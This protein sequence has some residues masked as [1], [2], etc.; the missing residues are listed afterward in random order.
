MVPNH[1]RPWHP[2]ISL[3][4]FPRLLC[5]G[6]GIASPEIPLKFWYPS[7]FLPRVVLARCGL[8]SL[9]ISGPPS[10]RRLEAI[11]YFQPRAVAY[12]LHLLLH[13]HSLP[14]AIVVHDFDTALFCCSAVVTRASPSAPTG[15]WYHQFSRHM[16]VRR[17][18][19]PGAE[20]VVRTR[21][22]TRA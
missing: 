16:L 12:R 21:P 18:G 5:S 14:V 6:R 15:M 8:S 19:S 22:R 13:H 3:L 10:Q 1:M 20:A 4:S 11:L 9:A 2:R 7:K 17:P